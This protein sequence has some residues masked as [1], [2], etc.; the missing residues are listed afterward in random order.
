MTTSVNRTWRTLVLKADPE[1][2]TKKRKEIEYDYSD[3]PG[4]RVFTG[5]PTNRGAYAD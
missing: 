2:E 5:N 4:G 3:Q 1:H